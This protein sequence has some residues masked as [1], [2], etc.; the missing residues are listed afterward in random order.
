MLGISKI[1]GEKLLL[2]PFDDL[3]I[4][5]IFGVIGGLGTEGKWCLLDRVLSALLSRWSDLVLPALLSR[6]R[7]LVLPA[8]LSLVSDRVLPA[9]LLRVNDLILP[10]LLSRLS[11]QLLG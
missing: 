5:D 8:L 6:V 2:E 1:N 9:L 11:V 10:A 7:D 3:S 4:L